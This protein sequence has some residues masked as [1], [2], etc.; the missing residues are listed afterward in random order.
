M[1]SVVLNSD[2]GGGFRPRC[3]AALTSYSGP[4]FNERHNLPHPRGILGHSWGEVILA[5]ERCLNA[6]DRKRNSMV[7][8][9]F[10]QD[11]INEATASYREVLYRSMEFF[12]NLTDNIAMSMSPNPRKPIKLAGPKRLREIVAL[13]CNKLK[14]NHN[15]IQYVEAIGGGYTV[16]GFAIYHVVRGALQPNP[17]IHKE[18]RAMSFNVELRRIFAAIYLYADEIA[19]IISK[20]ATGVTPA[21]AVPDA[22]TVA[23]IRRITEL[24]IFAMPFETERQMPSISFDGSR[25][26]IIEQG[27]ML[28]PAPLNC[29]MV[30]QYVGDGATTSFA[31][32]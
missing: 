9:S 4:L 30:A 8:P 3:F 1:R 14:H 11:L 15:R 28:F 32:P 22:R 21:N 26:S 13:P 12:E 18:R 27:G 23:T 6:L 19:E 17:E 10:D 24:P 29:Q 2:D 20:G 7:R 5:F 16:P 31:V 25:L